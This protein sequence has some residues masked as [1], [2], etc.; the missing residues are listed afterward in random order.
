MID[1]AKR[2]TL[3]AA[4]AIAGAG[5]V[6]GSGKLLA[7]GKRLSVGGDTTSQEL[8][9][10]SIQVSTRLSVEKNDLE[11][12]LTNTGNQPVTITQMT[13]AATVVPRGKFD[14]TALLSNGPLRL[15]VGES[16]AVPM[17][18]HSLSIATVQSPGGAS[19]INSL[20]QSMSIVTEGDSFAAVSIVDGAVAA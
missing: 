1:Q 8:E 13:P 11:V 3:K 2:K 4:T 15:A 14:F 12:V 5:V 9:L 7:A 20:R 19:L 6:F 17:Q 10:S 16:V 18:R